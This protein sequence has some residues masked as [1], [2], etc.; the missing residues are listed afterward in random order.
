[1]PPVPEEPLLK[2]TLNLYHADVVALR[3]R[4]GAGWSVEVRKMVRKQCNA[5]QTAAD[6][7]SKLGYGD[8]PYAE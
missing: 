3:K 4:Y 5:K 1:M 6:F 2:V 7:L 8:E